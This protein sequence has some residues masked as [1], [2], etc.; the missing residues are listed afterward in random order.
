MQQIKPASISE[1]RKE[2]D[3]ELPVVTLNR[4]ITRFFGI[5]LPLTCSLS[6]QSSRCK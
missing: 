3:Q 2:R 1:F 4:L 6:V 5:M